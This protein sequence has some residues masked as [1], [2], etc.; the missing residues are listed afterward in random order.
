MKNRFSFSTKIIAT[1]LVSISVS[2]LLTVIFLYRA[3]SSMVMDDASSISRQQV[4]FLVS[5]IDD[6]LSSTETSLST[7]ISNNDVKGYLSKSSVTAGDAAAIQDSLSDLCLD[8]SD[9]TNAYLYSTNQ[10][11]LYHAFSET[12]DIDYS[13]ITES[14]WI[15]T[16]IRSHEFHAS[17]Y[18]FGQTESL[19]CVIPI[20]NVNVKHFTGYCMGKISLRFFSDIFSLCD[21]PYGTLYLCDSY[22]HMIYSTNPDSKPTINIGNLSPSN[23]L[24]TLNHNLVYCQSI[25]KSDFRVISI[26]PDNI[27]S[28]A[29][30]N[31]FFI[32]LAVSLL[33]IFLTLTATIFLLRRF[34]HPIRSL[35]NTMALSDPDHLKPVP[36]SGRQDEIGVLE[37]K[38]NDMILRI[39]DMIETQYRSDLAVKDAQLHALQFQIN[40]HFVNNTLQMIGTLAAERD[41]MDI[42]SLLS[43]FS[44]M[45]YYCLKF[46][47]ETVT[48][49]DELDYLKD[50]I[51]IQNGR[52]PD[53]LV[54]YSDIDPRCGTLIIPKMS[55]QPI[56]E[57]SFVHSFTGIS[58]K[59]EI[60][61][62]ARCFDTFYQVT[63]IDNGCGMNEETLSQIQKK[64]KDTAYKKPFHTSGSIGLTNVNTRIKLLYGAEYGLKIESRVM[65][66]CRVTLTLPIQ[67]E[68]RNL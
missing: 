61:I 1:V 23:E 31:T 54:F 39:D 37:E 18:M 13:D 55:L 22:G 60:K 32:S 59:W 28:F 57:N 4:D 49:N 7:W 62:E 29:N 27:Y 53:K 44:R 11:A 10:K 34:L 46:K 42:Y 47:K 6:S 33:C 41:M 43:A 25:P 40:P 17:L 51:E 20:R 35:A 16:I 15:S 38:Y 52:F 30:T 9:F 64:L 26:C 56:I 14:Q 66:G 63:I 21:Y 2:I 5:Y 67:E 8:Q 12:T 58:Q 36:P 65:Q 19:S 48:L 45:F 50:Y 3:Y 24:Q 68:V